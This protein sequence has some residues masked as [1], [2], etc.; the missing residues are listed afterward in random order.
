ML[1]PSTT[2]A[3]AQA[4][5]EEARG[6]DHLGADKDFDDVL[7]RIEVCAEEADALEIFQDM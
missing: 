2:A 4:Q 6:I 1:H 7:V 5:E 3:L